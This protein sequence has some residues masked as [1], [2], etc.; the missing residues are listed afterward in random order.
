M[1]VRLAIIAISCL[2][3]CGGAGDSPDASTIDALP[4]QIVTL[5]QTLPPGLVEEGIW[6]ANPGDQIG[7]AISA[8]TAE[9]DWDI[10]AHNNGGTQDVA[11]GFSQM[12]ISYDF[13]PPESGPWY[14]LLRND[15]VTTLTIDIQMDLYGQ[16]TWQG[17]Q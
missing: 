2:S 14:L 4:R 12:S 6:Q 15:S 3:A 10:H 11:N 7:L 13:R 9:L 8:A 16:A 5:T 1:L 17:W